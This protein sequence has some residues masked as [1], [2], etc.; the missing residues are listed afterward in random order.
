MWSSI[1]LDREKINL[2][3]VCRS[4][5]MSALCRRALNPT[6]WPPRLKLFPLHCDLQ[7]R[8]SWCSAGPIHESQWSH[9]ERVG[10]GV[11]VPD[12]CGRCLPLNFCSN[13]VTEEDTS[14]CNSRYV[15]ACRGGEAYCWWRR[16]A[17]YISC[18][19]MRYGAASLDHPFA[20]FRR[21][22]VPSNSR[23]CMS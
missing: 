8:A 6:I 12:G 3:A 22:V 16:V 14:V 2:W 15:W 13:F 9:K 21:I 23:V 4:P 1:Q 17:W 20:T 7:L 19:R 18:E 11:G 5:T 10:H